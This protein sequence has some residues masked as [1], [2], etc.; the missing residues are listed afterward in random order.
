MNGQDRRIP[1]D[2]KCVIWECFFLPRHGITVQTS[3]LMN[4]H[5][6]SH[7]EITHRQILVVGPLVGYQPAFV[8]VK[9][10]QYGT[11][12]PV[13]CAAARI[14]G[15]PLE[16]VDLLSILY[17]ECQRS[18]P[19]AKFFRPHQSVQIDFE[20]PPHR[21]FAKLGQRQQHAFP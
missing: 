2:G 7:Q 15:A 17:V 10:Q 14:V 9:V 21:P 6:V 3:Q 20:V 13:P 19:L 8:R 16:H 18:Q 5:V 11:A 4:G 1:I 12:N